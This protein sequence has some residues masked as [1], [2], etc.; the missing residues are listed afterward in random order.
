MDDSAGTPAWLLC[1][2]I[3]NKAKSEFIVQAV[4]TLHK[5]IQNR[6]MDI[7][8]YTIAPPETSS[9]SE[10][11][12]VVLNKI[13]EEYESIKETYDSYMENAST[14]GQPDSGTVERTEKLR[15]FLLSLEKISILVHYGRMC[16]EW[17]HDVALDVKTKNPSEIISKTALNDNGRKEI[18]DFLLKNKAIANGGAFTKEEMQILKEARIRV[19]KAQ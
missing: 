10:R 15:K 17:M 6:N 16:D 18:I 19:Y 14:S 8:G 7:K 5:E 9:E 12:E 13:T 4:E 1:T 11:E 3:L 2:E